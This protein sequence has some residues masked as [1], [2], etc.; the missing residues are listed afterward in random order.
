M[1]N[2]QAPFAIRTPGNLI[3]KGTTI[4]ALLFGTATLNPASIAADAINT[5]TFAAT[6]VTTDMHVFV[7]PKQATAAETYSIVASRVSAADVVEVSLAN[8][9][10]AAQVPGSQ[11]WV[12]FAFK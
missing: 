11:T 7:M 2:T 3:S 8:A 12:W 10:A 4:N 6:G 5:E 9:S 1:A